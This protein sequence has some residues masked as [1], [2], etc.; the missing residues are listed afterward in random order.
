MGLFS[1]DYSYKVLGEGY[2]YLYARI[3]DDSPYFI[4]YKGS[5]LSSYSVPAS[6]L[7]LAHGETIN[8]YANTYFSEAF[9]EY[10]GMYEYPDGQ[11]QRMFSTHTQPP[12]IFS[13][14]D[15]GATIKTG[16]PLAGVDSGSAL[17]SAQIM[18]NDNARYG[19]SNT[20]SFSV[21]GS[22]ANGTNIPALKI[23][24]IVS[25][26]DEPGAN[27]PLNESSGAK[28]RK[29][30]LNG[31]PLSDEK[32]Q[33]E[34]ETDQSKEETF[35]D[36]LTLGLRHDTTDTYMS[37]PAADLFLGARRS[38]TSDIWNIRRGL[39]PDERPDRPFGTG[40]T[41]NLA[42]GMQFTR[43]LG[44]GS[45]S[46]DNPDTATVTDENGASYSF[47]ILYP[48]NATYDPATGYAGQ[49]TF[50]PMPTSKHEQSTHLTTLVKDGANYVLKRKFGSTLTYAMSALAVSIPSDRIEG[51]SSG[52]D[53]K[54]ARLVSV[55][56]HQDL[57]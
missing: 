55:V 27:I 11:Q 16:S 24:Y 7:E 4:N 36:A 50:V 10:V 19:D 15:V 9:A 38:V 53:N 29:I 57:L 42:A 34:S 31:A 37:V 35:I 43:V 32:P 17:D 26:A 13:W 39:K 25:R 22:V 8:S 28:Y 14:S 23:N 12:L 40:W 18:L 3:V 56:D 49:M 44:S 47:A 2:S 5:V 30:A 45:G 1:F 6:G 33:Q 48:A 46:M 54:W 41:S 20:I 52:Q 51:S 21:S